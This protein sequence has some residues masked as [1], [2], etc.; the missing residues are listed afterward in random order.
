MQSNQGST[1]VEKTG[2]NSEVDETGG[3]KL[4]SPADM[5]AKQ[6]VARIKREELEARNTAAQ[7]NP[8]ATIADPYMVRVEPRYDIVQN[9]STYMV[10]IPDLKTGPEDL[11]LTLQP[12]EIIKLTDFYSP[13]EI[14]RSKGLR[15]VSTKL[16]SGLGEGAYAVVGL[17]SEEEGNRF[18][19][20]KKRV[21]EKGETFEDNVPNDFDRR[22][23]ELEA[24]D[25]KANE[26]LLRKTL[27]SRTTRLHGAAPAHV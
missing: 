5:A 22:F 23:E 2:I 20:P 4:V 1:V 10:V 11:G 21:R 12:G 14:N 15:Y 6:E 16:L 8:N 3:A 17:K 19:L 26:R 9:Q 7:G 27:A 13:L 25:A 18:V 24:K